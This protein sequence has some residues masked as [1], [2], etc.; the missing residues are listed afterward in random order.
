[1]T[2]SE[3]LIQRLIQEGFLSEGT[4]TA[5][6]LYPGYWQ[7]KEGAWSWC[8]FT[9]EGREANVGSQWSMS[10]VLRAREIIVGNDGGLYPSNEEKP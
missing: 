9:A 6:R 1:M 8:V 2:T 5:Q 4:Y 10:E 3:K 7:R